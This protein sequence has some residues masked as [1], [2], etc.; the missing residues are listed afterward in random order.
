M[1]FVFARVFL[2]WLL[3]ASYYA[4]AGAGAWFCELRQADAA[5]VAVGWLA[6]ASCPVQTAVFIKVV[7]RAQSRPNARVFSRAVTGKAARV[8]QTLSAC[9]STSGPCAAWELQAQ[10]LSVT[11]VSASMSSPLSTSPSRL[12]F[13]ALHS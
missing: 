1:S 5:S 4:C 3:F 12:L 7:S 11:G 6:A 10:C 13:S 8:W 9:P 2:A